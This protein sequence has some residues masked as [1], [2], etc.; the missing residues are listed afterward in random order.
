ME[1]MVEGVLIP[2]EDLIVFDLAKKGIRIQ[3]RVI[4]QGHGYALR[5][6]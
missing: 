4:L 2:Q 3:Q 5:A 6:E 1:E